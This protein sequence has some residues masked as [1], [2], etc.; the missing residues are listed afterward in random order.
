MITF[1]LKWLAIRVINYEI[2]NMTLGC[3][4]REGGGSQTIL[5]KEISGGDPNVC[6]VC[7]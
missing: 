6:I 7:N 3:P 1:N 4:V 5:I 2:M